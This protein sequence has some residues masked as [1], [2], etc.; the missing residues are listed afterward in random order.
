MPFMLPVLLTIPGAVFFY[1][2]A[3]INIQTLKKVR[4]RHLLMPIAGMMV[5][6][7]YWILPEKARSSMFLM[8][9]LPP[10]YTPSILAF[11]TFALILIWSIVSFVYLVLVL[12]SLN[13]YRAS[14]KDLVSNTEV[15]SLRWVESL[16][17]GF[18]TLWI[19]TAVSLVG[20]NLGLGI[21]FSNELPL[22]VTAAVLLLLFSFPPRQQPELEALGELTQ[23]QTGDAE[24]HTPAVK[25]S[26]SALSMERKERLSER[27]ENC[28]SSKRL[29][30]DPNLTLK[31]LSD[32]IG[33]T[34]NTVS[35]TLN[36][37]IGMSFFDYVASWRAKAAKS[38]L[39]TTDKTVL[40]ICLE[41][42]FNSRCTFYKAFKN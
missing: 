13:I 32:H 42:G 38:L 5:T 28:M 20:D 1:I 34:T 22:F 12:K 4:P 16:M 31:K 17:F 36:E 21:F 29:F 27:I 11:A 23:Q 41:V 19:I 40:N 10:G 39:I 14:L 18:V 26:K 8:G 24:P 37:E 30:L 25:Y 35:Q 9:E 3:R 2:S 15:Y 6:I 33:A 7:G